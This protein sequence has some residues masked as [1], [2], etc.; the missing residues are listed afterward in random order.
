M[1]TRGALGTDATP[2]SLLFDSS[3]LYPLVLDA[4]GWR[5]AG[6]DPTT[7]ATLESDRGVK[8]GVVP[9]IRIGSFDVPR[10]GA[11][12]S[13]E[14][15]GLEKG[16]GMNLDG[17]VGSGLLAGFRITF[18]ENGKVLWFED[19]FLVDPQLASPNQPSDESSE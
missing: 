7:L 6:V 11:V 13:S 2:A 17:I 12:L 16:L 9:A 18:A 10:V 8:H 5:K 3:Q 19:D 1:V 15:D 14:V 4:D